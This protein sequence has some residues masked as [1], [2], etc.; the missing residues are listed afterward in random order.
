MR[1]RSGVGLSLCVEMKNTSS[2]MRQTLRRREAGRTRTKA[3]R[4]STTS[5]TKDV[6]QSWPEADGPL[7]HHTALTN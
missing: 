6:N 4:G 3:H 5:G 1:V 7:N 2:Q